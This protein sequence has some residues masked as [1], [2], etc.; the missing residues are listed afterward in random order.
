MIFKRKIFFFLILHIFCLSF[1]LTADPVD[2]AVPGSSSPVINANLYQI[3]GTRK[4]VVASVDATSKINLFMLDDSI[5]GTGNVI[6]NAVVDYAACNGAFN[7]NFGV[8]SS[9]SPPSYAMITNSVA[10]TSNTVTCTGDMGNYNIISFPTTGNPIITKQTNIFSKV[11][12]CT[13]D[14]VVST[15]YVSS[16]SLLAVFMLCK[17]R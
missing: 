15:Q 1:V 11:S 6:G 13:L 12:T 9:T 5:T 8:I 10:N 16:N 7:L 4:M 2:Y 3:S 17:T 14:R